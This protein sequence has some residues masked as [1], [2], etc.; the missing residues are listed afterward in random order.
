MFESD[1][2]SD[3]EDFS[4][5]TNTKF[6]KSYDRARQKEL[7]KKLKEHE[8]DSEE[9][10]S[11][12]EESEEDDGFADEEFDKKFFSTLASIKAR[13]PKIYKKD[14]EFFGDVDLSTRKRSKE[15][16]PI[17]I[18]DLERKV[19]LEHGGMFEEV[20]SKTIGPPLIT[21]EEKEDKMMF[22]LSDSDDE[23]GFDKLYT[24]KKIEV[25]EENEEEI[26]PDIVEPM[27]KFWNDSNI[28]KDEAFLRDFVLKRPYAK[29][30]DSDEE[31]RFNLSEDEKDLEKQAEFEQKV[32]FRFEEQDQE[33]IKRFPRTIATSVRNVDDRRKKKRA[34]LK[35]RKARE[36]E[37]RKK[38]IEKLKELK[39]QEIEEKIN[40]L[41]QVAG[42]E[43]IQFDNADLSDEFDPDAHDRKMQQIF[44]DEY[45]GIDEGEDKPECPDIEDLKVQDWDNYD[46]DDD[47]EGEDVAVPHCDDPDFNMDCEYDPQAAK[48]EFE[49]EMIENTQSRK[50]R[51]RRSKF[52]EVLR[53]DKPIFNP[54]DEKTY[55]EYI[56]EY[57]KL[58]CEDVIGDVKCRFKYVETV[59]NDF[60]LTVEEILMAKNKEL[61]KWASLKKAVQIRPKHVE[62]NEIQ[63]YDKRRQN[64]FLKKQILRSV[65]GEDSEEEDADR[66]P[67]SIPKLYEKDEKLKNS[68][69]EN[70]TKGDKKKKIKIQNS[71]QEKTSEK[72]K[73]TKSFE[74]NHKSDLIFKTPSK[75]KKKTEKQSTPKSPKENGLMKKK[76]PK[77]NQKEIEEMKPNPEMG[78]KKKKRKSDAMEQTLQNPAKK[79]KFSKSSG[80]KNFGKN[81]PKKKPTN[82]VIGYETSQG[83]FAINTSRLMA[84]GINPKKFRSKVKYGGADNNKN[85]Q[86]YKNK[87]N[88]PGKSKKQ[89]KKKNKKKSQQKQTN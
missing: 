47:E 40:K 74:E 81:E 38:E 83:K 21:K 29:V 50:R 27:K 63:Q 41:K 89:K 48:K 24:T 69:S 44:N 66:N 3:A 34:E 17:T 79:F 88:S 5:S 28:S 87:N 25:E 8:L 49:K 52:A 32:N 37:E 59:P 42:S 13:D 26:N 16:K 84:F 7:M 65:Y 10:S 68:D 14:V 86:Q 54:E 80:L 62:M 70:I 85:N 33:F 67:N 12:S 45:Y 64:W 6:A 60:G 77:E 58:D 43:N 82:E 9:S 72:T 55:A 11:E 61:N 23:E 51:K 2:N 18:R 76:N 46:P 39:K 1:S 36:K 57:Y 56:D 15:D 75:N 31:D 30:D 73:E 78:E 20:D 22:H 19:L 4:F 71:E 53:K 35:E